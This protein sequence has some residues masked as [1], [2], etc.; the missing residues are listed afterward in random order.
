MICSIVNQQYHIRGFVSTLL[1]VWDLLREKFIFP[2]F[3]SSLMVEGVLGCESDS[4]LEVCEI[5][6]PWARAINGSLL[7]L[8]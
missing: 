3:L 1:E 8:K 7:S 5:E 4:L 2:K 6:I